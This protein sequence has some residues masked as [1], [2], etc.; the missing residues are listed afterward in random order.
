MNILH[1]EKTNKNYWRSRR[2]TNKGTF[3][4]SK[5]FLY[6]EPKYKLNKIVEMENKYHRNDLIYEI[7][8]KKREKTYDFEKLRTIKYFER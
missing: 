1:K 7:G 8:N 5:D 4:F 2:K 6:E 3:L